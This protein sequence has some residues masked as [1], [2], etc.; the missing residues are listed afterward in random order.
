MPGKSS[1]REF[2]KRS[3]TAAGALSF[4]ARSYA[5]IVGANNIVR[6]G[7]IGY[8][9]R[10]RE[11]LFPAFLKHAGNQQFEIAAL[12][13]IWKRRRDEGVALITESTGHHVALCRNNDE[14][15]DRKDIDAVI[16]A[17]PDH[18]HAIPALHAMRA[19][20]DMYLEKPVG[21]TVEE[22][23]VL[24][25]EA[26][27]TG[28]LLEVGLQ[29]RSGT[30][31]AEAARLIRE[32]ALGNI[33]LVHCLNVWNQSESGNMDYTILRPGPFARSRSWTSA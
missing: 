11:A 24:M 33:T 27:R 14:L 16:I 9:D 15:Y 32:G 17:T 28:R 12:S 31:F 2:L 6:T 4:P 8:S 10:F 21:H 20:K 19:G 13:D 1:R 25:A 3:A 26:E 7:V 30:L 18:W 22:R 5:R 29:Q 23:A